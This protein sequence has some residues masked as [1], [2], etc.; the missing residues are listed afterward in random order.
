MGSLNDAGLREVETR[1]KASR[2][3]VHLARNGAEVLEAFQLRHQVFVREMRA[4]VPTAEFGVDCDQFDP[5][6]DHLI[7]RDTWRGLL[8]G[9]YRI[10]GAERTAAT[11]GFYSER[12]FDLGGIRRLGPRIAELGRA[13]VH[14]EYRKGAVIALLWAGLFK[15]MAR[16]GYQYAIGCSSISLADGGCAAAG[17]CRQ[18]IRD[19]P[20]PHDWRVKPRNPFPLEEFGETGPAP[21]PPLI[22]GYVRL[23]AYVC[24]NPA[25]DS[26]FNT[27]D[28]LMLLPM[29]RISLRY[30][31]RFERSL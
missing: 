16:H 26:D 29:E 23:G 17:I 30:S 19:Y 14:R 15:Y 28:L 2:F 12:E 18:L 10:L 6:C 5:C 24:G 11:G 3:A 25:L 27:A 9:T 22:K 7:V 21:L 1:A 4:R 13:C 20:S 31:A 8:V